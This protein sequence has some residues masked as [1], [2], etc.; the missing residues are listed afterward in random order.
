MKKHTKIGKFLAVKRIEKGIAQNEMA[1]ML[2]V[3]QAYLSGVERGKKGLGK[4]FA[5]KLYR[6]PIWS[7]SE[8]VEL[9]AVYMCGCL[10]E[11]EL[12]DGDLIQAAAI[13]AAA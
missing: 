2:E 4:K 3:K 5:A 7:E 9:L 1:E 8:R 12:I 13:C 6:L 11:L 10:N